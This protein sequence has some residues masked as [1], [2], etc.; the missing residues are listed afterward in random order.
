MDEFNSGIQKELN[1]ISALAVENAPVRVRLQNLVSTVCDVL[2]VP[3]AILLLAEELPLSSG[4]LIAGKNEEMMQLLRSWA[5]PPDNGPIKNPSLIKNLLADSGNANPYCRAVTDVRGRAHELIVV[6]LLIGGQPLGVIVLASHA[7]QQLLEEQSSLLHLLV[8]QIGLVLLVLKG[9]FLEASKPPRNDNWLTEEFL[10]TLSHELRAPLHAI[11]GWVSVL[12]HPATHKETWDHALK[13]I[14][15]SARTQRHIINDLLDASFCFNQQAHLNK[16]PVSMSSILRQV[17]KSMLPVAQQKEISF[18]HDIR[19]EDDYALADAERLRQVFWH[20]VSNA[21]K[22]TTRK[23]HIRLSAQR[24]GDHCEITLKDSG[25]GI[26][27]EF[28]PYV[29]DPF[30]QESA[31]TTRKFGG[32]GLGLA[33][34]RHQ[35]ELHGGT[36]D[37]TSAGKQQGT[38]VVMRLPLEPIPL[39]CHKTAD[40]AALLELS[41]GADEKIDLAGVRVLVVDDDADSLEIVSTI[42]QNCNSEVQI[43]ANAQEALNVLNQWEPDI[44]ISDIQMPGGDGYELIQ[45]I[46]RQKPT[47]RGRIAAV[48]L[49]AYSRAE[50]RLKALASGFH[51]HLSKPIDPK[52]LVA[53]VT[54]LVT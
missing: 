22:F 30:R 45:Q 40:N 37:I 21:I 52:E 27:P 36:I 8:T 3:A 1:S 17:L 33:I 51:T 43:A 18:T 32:L 11:L 46:R 16:R 7:P 49:T 39:I 12:Q 9:S 53:V 4:L 19:I 13:T 25:I 23:G 20:L 29:F 14:E 31:R 48:A 15:R 44:L 35:V 47:L 5:S 26:A 41:N 24:V 28:M 6:P 42:L 54:R 2:Q 34:V 50:D 10:A 38:T